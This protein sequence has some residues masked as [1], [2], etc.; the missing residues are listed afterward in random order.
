VQRT[1][2]ARRRKETRVCLAGKRYSPKEVPPGSGD[3]SKSGIAAYQGA[4]PVVIS[5]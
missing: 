5:I 2:C 3:H 1:I 4:L